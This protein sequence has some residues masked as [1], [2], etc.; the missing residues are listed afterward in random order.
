LEPVGVIVQFGGQTPINLAKGLMAAGVPLLGTPADSIDICEDRARFQQLLQR[1]GIRQ[2]A[3]GAAVNVEGAIT[4]ANQIGY[5]VVVR[6]SYVLGGR[7]MEIVYDDDSLEHYMEEAVEASEHRPVLIDKFLEDAIEVDVDAIGDGECFVIGGI[8]EHIE[9]AGIHSGDSCC[10]LPTYSLS[11]AIVARIREHTLDMARALNVI[12]LMNV[13]YAVKGDTVYVLEVNPRASRTVPFVAKATGVP[14]A[15]LAAKVQAGAKLRDLGFTREV[16][17]EHFAVKV[18]VFPFNK[19]PGVDTIL[20]PEMRSTG[21]VMGIDKNFGAGFAK[22][23]LAADFQLPTEG[24]V[25]VSVKDADK[26][27]ISGM[28]ARLVSMGF[29][30]IATQGTYKALV[31]Q[32]IPIERVNKIHEGRPHVIDLIKNRQVGLI[33][34]TPLGKLERSDDCLIRSTAVSYKVP[35]ITNLAAAAAGIQA[36]DVMKKGPL[37]VVRLQD[38]HTSGVF[39]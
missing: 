4:I 14:L 28:A 12:G 10:S 35:C 11:D 34:N 31:N 29:E 7:A 2:P 32:G 38:L 13:Q 36:I 39:S 5:P 24:R 33:I 27:L 18:P 19:F 6:P 8:M 15:K 1:L 9:E 25:F 23:M 26:R 20:G 22:A 3:N 37:D 17:P 16:T 21:E 30:L